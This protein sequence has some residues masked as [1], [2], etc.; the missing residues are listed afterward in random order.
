MHPNAQSTTIRENFLRTDTSI[1]STIP[2]TQQGS[3]QMVL[4]IA[5]LIDSLK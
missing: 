3:I 4:G 5:T 2:P 1:Y